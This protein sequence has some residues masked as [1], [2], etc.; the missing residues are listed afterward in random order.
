MINCCSEK[1]IAMEKPVSACAACGAIGRPVSTLTLKHMVKPQ[2]LAMVTKP[3]FRFCGSPNCDVV[4]YHS[5]GEQL[6]K[7]NLRI[8]VGVKEAEEPAAPLCYCFGFTRAMLV[9][10]L[11]QDGDSQMPRQISEEVKAGNCA[12]TARN[13]QGSCCLGNIAAAIKM[14]QRMRSQTSEIT[15]C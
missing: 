7:T 5:D 2:F 11:C 4:Y 13:P 6:N 3:G 14:W 8:L 9:E 10:E 1:P 15:A 12:C